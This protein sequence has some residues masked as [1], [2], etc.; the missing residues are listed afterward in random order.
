[1]GTS[2]RG[3]ESIIK[4]ESKTRFGQIFIQ[5]CS[6]YGIAVSLAGIYA[7]QWIPDKQ[8]SGMT[9]FPHYL[10]INNKQ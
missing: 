4:L 9:N 8:T 1:M 10:P 2:I 5:F 7:Q 6:M 3:Y